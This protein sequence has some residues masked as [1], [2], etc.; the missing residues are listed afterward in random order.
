MTTIAMIFGMLPVAIGLGHGGEFRAPLA[1]AVIG[2]LLLSTM[3]T[4]LVIPCVYTYFDDFNL[5]LSSKVFR[6]KG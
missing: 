1:V 4:L 5:F 3:L 2:G 6:R